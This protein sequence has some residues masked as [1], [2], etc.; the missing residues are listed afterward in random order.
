MKG[1]VGGASGAYGGEEKSVLCFGEE[2][3]KSTWNTYT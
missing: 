3:W 2:T 1:E